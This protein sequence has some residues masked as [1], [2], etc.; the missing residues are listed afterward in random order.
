MAAVKLTP[1]P[2]EPEPV[3]EPQ[4]DDEEDIDENDPLWKVTFKLAGG[5]RE[6]VRGVVREPCVSVRL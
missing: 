4:G 6:K 2:K 3:E 5:V 1:E